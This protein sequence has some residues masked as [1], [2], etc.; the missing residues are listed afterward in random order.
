MTIEAT[1]N[2]TL[3]GNAGNSLHVRTPGDFTASSVGGFSSIE[4]NNVTGEKFGSHTN[5]EAQ[6]TVKIGELGKLGS[7]N[8]RNSITVIRSMGSDF[9]STYGPIN[10]NKNSTVEP[11]LKKKRKSLFGFKL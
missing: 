3:E 4:A 2:I 9:V 1:G 5:I 10:V 6:D 8:A 7:V 11:P